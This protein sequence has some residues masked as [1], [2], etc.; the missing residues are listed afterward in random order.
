[1]IFVLI[2]AVGMII[3][4]TNL[5]ANLQ[6]RPYTKN[7]HEVGIKILEPIFI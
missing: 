2:Q 5:H 1:M 3:M 6:V 4:K 7:Q